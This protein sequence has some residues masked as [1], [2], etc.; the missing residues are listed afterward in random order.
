MSEHFL[1]NSLELPT[2]EM[3]F[4]DFR[5]KG[6]RC[7]SVEHLSN[8]SEDYCFQSPRKSSI[9]TLKP[10]PRD[11]PASFTC[12]ELHEYKNTIELYDIGMNI[13]MEIPHVVR[14]VSDLQ[15][16]T[17]NS[18]NDEV[19]AGDVLILVDNQP[20]HNLDIDSL[21]SAILGEK[22]SIVSLTLKSKLPGKVK[23]LQVRR[24]VLV[25]TYDTFRRFVLVH[26]SLSGLL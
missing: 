18:L 5:N 15:D 8:I 1:S 24:H 17:G 2:Q 16:A 26:W 7:I 12:L 25:R 3:A 21:E 10:P 23:Q 4:V 9:E 20:I 22:D 6:F 14:F 11:M 13:N 19:Q